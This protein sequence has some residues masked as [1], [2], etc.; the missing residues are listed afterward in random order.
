MKYLE[1]KKHSPKFREGVARAL[2]VPKASPYF[3]RILAQYND[4]KEEHEVVR[5]SIA[6]AIC[7][8]ARTQEQL[9]IVEQMIYDEKIG[10][11]RNA[12]TGAMRRM[13]GEQKERC[14]AYV[15][16]DEKLRINLH[17]R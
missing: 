3:D 17:S 7:A 11:D 13:K 5:W 16:A 14:L 9:N 1:E 15:K 10:N 8:S 4:A 12:L 2:A 6:C